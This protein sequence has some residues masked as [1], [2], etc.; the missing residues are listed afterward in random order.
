MNVTLRPAELADAS[1]ICTLILGLAHYSTL[2][3]SGAGAERFLATFTR[4]AIAGYIE[5]SEFD[6]WVACDGSQLVGAAAVRKPRHLYHLFVAES[7][8]GR[9]IARRL[10]ETLHSRMETAGDSPV[11]VNSTL[12]AVPVYQRFGFVATGP[13]TARDGIVF[14]PMELRPAGRAEPSSSS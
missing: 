14:V 7:H 12:H 9:G 3:P 5:R 10:W 8:H 2:D 6:Y 11:T 1:E 4:E 13:E